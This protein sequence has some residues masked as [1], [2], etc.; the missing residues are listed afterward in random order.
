MVLDVLLILDAGDSEKSHGSVQCAHHHL[1]AMGVPDHNNVGETQLLGILVDLWE[2]EI[3]PRV[4]CYIMKNH[5][6]LADE[7]VD[8]SV[9]LKTSRDEH[10]NLG[11]LS[12][13]FIELI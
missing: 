10:F 2:L 5:H 1:K 12:E 7:V 4:I 9:W 8:L 6:Q 3:P 11:L 13:E